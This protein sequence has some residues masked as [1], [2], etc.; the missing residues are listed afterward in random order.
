MSCW[1]NLTRL[2]F[3]NNCPNLSLCFYACW[4]ILLLAGAHRQV[5]LNLFEDVIKD[6]NNA[7]GRNERPS[8]IAEQKAQHDA[9]DKALK[10]R[11]K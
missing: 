1:R 6:P 3:R 7:W 2:I 8:Y 11:M 5:G 9:F 10:K 4:F